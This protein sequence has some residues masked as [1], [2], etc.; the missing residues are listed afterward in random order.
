MK[1][2]EPPSASRFYQRAGKATDP[3]TRYLSDLKGLTEVVVTH[4][5]YQQQRNPERGSAAHT[6]TWKY[7]V[8]VSFIPIYLL[9]QHL[10][11]VNDH[12]E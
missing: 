6:H 4:Q 5:F 1:E 10:V 12:E 11:I 2:N 9:I 8:D 7:M 3:P